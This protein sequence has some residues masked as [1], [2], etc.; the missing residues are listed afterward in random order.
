[1]S[2]INTINLDDAK[3]PAHRFYINVVKNDSSQEYEIYKLCFCRY[4]KLNNL[5][6]LP[7]K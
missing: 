3:K 7:H 6:W 1:M 4:F 5:G 2:T